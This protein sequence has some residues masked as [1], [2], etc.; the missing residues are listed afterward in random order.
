MKHHE[1][2]IRHLH[3]LEAD[4][5][6]QIADAQQLQRGQKRV[7]GGFTVGKTPP[8]ERMAPAVQPR[9]RRARKRR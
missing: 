6:R 7:V 5:D 1:E 4:L 8:A 9:S 3:Q 2:R